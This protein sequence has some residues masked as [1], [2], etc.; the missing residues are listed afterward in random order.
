MTGHLL[1][2]YSRVDLALDFSTYRFVNSEIS[3]YAR[4]RFLLVKTVIIQCV[5]KWVMCFV[6][7]SL[8]FLISCILS[9]CLA[10]K[11]VLG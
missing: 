8:Y 10:S 9:V 6:F 7:S 1:A 11:S 3:V 2:V 4:A 5:F